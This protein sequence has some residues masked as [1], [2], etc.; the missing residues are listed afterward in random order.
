MQLWY[1]INNFYIKYIY[2]K[3]IF[4]IIDWFKKKFNIMTNF[5]KYII[6]NFKKL[7]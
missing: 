6:F 1:I 5:I 4:L 2:I 7:Y 3:Y